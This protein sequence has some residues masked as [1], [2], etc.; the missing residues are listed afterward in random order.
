MV[1]GKA[2]PAHPKLIM[3]FDLR[4]AAQAMMKE[5][6]N[7]FSVVLSGTALKSQYNAWV[8]AR[9]WIRKEDSLDDLIKLKDLEKKRKDMPQQKRADFEKEYRYLR[10]L[11]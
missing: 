3:R 6:E 5:L 1:H 2:G 9:R 8:K 10:V 4:R 11:C 7:G